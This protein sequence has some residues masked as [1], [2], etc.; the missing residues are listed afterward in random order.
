MRLHEEV[1]AEAGTR[2][3]EKPTGAQLSTV[4]PATMRQSAH[5]MRTGRPIVDVALVEP[6]QVFS[7][8]VAC[9]RQMP[10][11]LPEGRKS[12]REPRCRLIPTTSREIAC[13][14][15]ELLDIGSS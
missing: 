8:R 2:V 13:C 3:D 1:R 12:R 15:G 5:S 9:S 4:D 14:C 10:P 6:A 7:D 11:T